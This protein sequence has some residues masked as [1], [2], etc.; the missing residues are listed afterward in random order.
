METWNLS[1]LHYSHTP[2]CLSDVIPTWS[3]A[4]AV[5]LLLGV[6]PGL[7]HPGEDLLGEGRCA[8][9]GSPA[10]WRLF[11]LGGRAVGAGRGCRERGRLL[12]CRDARGLAVVAV[13]AAS[14][15]TAALTHAVSVQLA[16]LEGRWP[17]GGGLDGTHRALVVAVQ[18]GCRVGLVRSTIG[19]R[20]WLG[21]GV[22]S[23]ESRV[24]V[25]R[26]FLH[27]GGLGSKAINRCDLIQWH[28]WCLI[29]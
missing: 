21:V 16:L 25:V 6:L 9:V 28:G 23:K 3:R 5:A 7:L 1:K 12:L 13:A 2:S 29:K 15:L 27:F 22:A 18:A 10:G 11:L 26:C 14:T 8:A 20:V 19:V 17:H 24:I 4:A